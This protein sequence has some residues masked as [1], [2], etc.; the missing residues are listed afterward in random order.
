M[1]VNTLMKARNLFLSLVAATLCALQMNAETQPSNLIPEKGYF[2]IQGKATQVPEDIKSFRLAVTDLFMGESFDI[3][4]QQDGTFQQ[5]LPVIGRQNMYL[6]LGDAITISVCPGDTLQLTFDYTNCPASV[7]LTG[8]TPERSKELKLDLELD[9]K[10]RSSYL[11]LSQEGFKPGALSDT[12]FLNKIK[13]YVD[14]Y[15]KEIQNFEI[16]YGPLSNKNLLLYRGYFDGI[17]VS[18]IATDPNA[19]ASAFFRQKIRCFDGEQ[20]EQF[21]L[22]QSPDFNFFQSPSALSF[23]GA[24]FRSRI[25][26]LTY[27]WKE[28]STQV[29]WNR[30]LTLTKACIPNQSLREWYE[31]SSFLLELQMNQGGTNQELKE[32]GERILCSL[33]TP[34]IKEK[35]QQLMKTYFSQMKPGQTAPDFTLMNEKGEAVSL[36]S[37]KGKVIY[38][39]IWAIGC[40]P[41]RHEFKQLKALHKKYAAYED[42][43]AYVYVCVGSTEKQWKSALKE[44]GLKGI[45]LHA[46]TGKEEGFASYYG[47]F[48]PL[49]VLIDKDG[50]I[51]E[52]NS[53]LRP[54]VLLKDSP[55]LL[56]EL[57]KPSK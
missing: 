38:L 39:D 47:N 40:G 44:F 12:L 19:L 36:S 57:L 17:T 50:K 51:A 54:S 11:E 13:Q 48:F 5:Q 32:I 22:Y 42:D 21:P 9:R 18:W 28:E 52:Y 56:D 10:F 29:Q 31:V 20:T 53:P 23:A 15:R 55:N 30:I 49:Y 43:I 45:L 34:L 8:T 7:L 2:V 24:Y 46:P 33:T 25:Y 1:N 16:K 35:M 26:P 14:G 41:C 27:L 4:F 37:L 3:P 6:Y